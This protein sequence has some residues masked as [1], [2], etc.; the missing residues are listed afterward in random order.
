VSDQTPQDKEKDFLIEE[1]K[2]CWEY[3]QFHYEQRD[4]SQRFYFIFVLAGGS[5]VAGLVKLWSKSFSDFP[6]ILL[7][8]LIIP[9]FLF[10]IFC[11]EQIISLRKTTTLFHKTIVTIRAQLLK[12]Y[13][14]P[15]WKTDEKPTFYNKGFNYSTTLIVI[16]ITGFIFAS[17]VFVIILDLEIGLLES[18][19]FSILAGIA[20][21]HFQI[22]RY[23]NSLKKEDET[24]EPLFPKSKN[25]G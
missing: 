1:Y 17:G 15:L 12:T 24:Y 21:G 6:A 16:G 23:S 11:L 20:I 10:G 19:F 9:L 4:R 5:V 2:R 18:L 3:I 22:K 25:G 14:T 7:L 13:S 8:L